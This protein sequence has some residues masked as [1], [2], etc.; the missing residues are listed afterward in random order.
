MEGM[1][2]L[3]M[4]LGVVLVLG[5]IAGTVLPALPGAPLVFGGLLLV[6]WAEHFQKV[7]WIPLTFIGLLAALTFP[8]DLMAASLGAKR[9]GASW[10]ALVGA[11]IG[12]V[13]GFFLGLPGL[14]LGPFVG[15]V[16]GEYLA[17]R[18]LRQAG[19]VGVGT[20]IGFIIG[21]AGKMALIFMMIGI[22]AFAYVV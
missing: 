5:G 6:A 9:V 4:V 8:L 17:R 10:L 7:G 16:L 19:R 15:A 18:D 1:E 21:V 20:W 14:I 3:L 13:V 22:F 11:A 2:A 12:T